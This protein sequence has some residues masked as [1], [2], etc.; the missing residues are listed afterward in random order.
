MKPALLAALVVLLCASTL[1]PQITLN[2]TLVTLVATVTDSSGR[3]I[4]NLGP[5]DFIVTEDGKE[6]KIALVEQS[7][8]LPV[9]IGVVLDAS[10]SM[11]TKIETATKAIERF[12]RSLNSS[13]D[14]F[15]MSFAARPKL[16]QNFTNDRNKIAKALHNVKLSNQTALYDAVEQA[17]VKVHDGKH[18]KKA[19]LLVTDGQDTVSQ[20]RYN[21]VL[22][23]VRESHV[24]VYALGIGGTPGSR[25]GQPPP[26]PPGT[27]GGS[28]G[29]TPT[30]RL[31]GGVQIPIPGGPIL[32]Q[33]PSQG[34]GGPPG[35]N[36]DSAD[37]RVLDGLAGASGAKA[38]L[39]TTSSANSGSMDSVLD[40][41]AAELRSQYTIGYYPDHAVN[42]GKWHQV[43]VRAKNP[44]YEVR[45]R[46]EYLGR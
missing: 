33:F 9:S 24:L 41:I 34:R 40:E 8:E 46:K 26:P 18:T 23:D 7:D 2:V 3:Y 22:D 38:F 45:S 42:D 19:L 44:R 1:L 4:R 5:E 17:L 16:E 10:T 37:M 14:M 25:G 43:N 39:V 13:D 36:M 32:R 35:I 27:P 20:T 15:L 29:G 31:P 28:R 6:Q 30:I 21:R 12:L 11:R